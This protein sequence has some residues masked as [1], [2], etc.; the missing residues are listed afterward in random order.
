LAGFYIITNTSDPVEK[1]LPQGQYEVPLA[2]QD[3]SFYNDGS[4]YYPTEGLNPSIHPYWQ[5]SFLGNTIVVNGQAW[6]NM[7]VKQ[8]LYRFRILDGS[9]SRFYQISLSNGM[10]FTQIGTDGGY[11][12]A[13]AQMTSELI[14]PGER[15]D[16]LVDFSNVPAGQKIILENFAGASSTEQDA[17]TTGHIMQFTVTGEKGAASKPLPSNLNPTLTGDYP[18]LPQPSKTR[19]LTLTDIAGP[20]GSAML[21][22]DGQTWSATVS[23]KPKLGSTEDWVIVNPTMDAHPIHIHLVQFQIVKRQ[24][25]ATLSYM[26]KWTS[27]NGDPPLNHTTV[28]VPS[29]DPY[30][31]GQPTGPTASEQGWKDTVVVNS[32]EVVI[33]RLRWAEQNGNPFP[34]DATAGPG[35]VWHCH[36]LEHEDNEMMRPYVVV[37]ASSNLSLEIAVAVIVVAAVIAVSVV[38]YFKRSRRHTAKP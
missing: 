26:D 15:V 4:L 18:T 9:N 1:L 17:Q 5:N 31:A 20:N 2:I 35:Y 6:P 19:I 22:L 7:D 38:L 33:I 34:F 21:L 11:L 36:M 25:F 23:E 16:I 8:G 24:A 29:I 10:A 37:G 32:G 30:L 14:A 13:P 12:K 3:R 28:N 27:L